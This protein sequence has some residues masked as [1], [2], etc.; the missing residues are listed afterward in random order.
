MLNRLALRLATVRAL[1]GR[2]LAGPNVLDSSSA[3]IDDIAAEHPTP[4]IVVYTDDGQWN[5]AGRDLYATSG[6]TRV[7]MGYQKLLIEI[8][9][10]QRMLL[11]DPAT[12]E[13]QLDADGNP[14]F[15]AMSLATDPALELTLDLIERQVIDALMCGADDAAWPE[16]WRRLVTGVGDKHS[17][18]GASARDGVRFAGRQIAI[19]CALP[20]EPPPAVPIGPLWTDFLALAETEPDL[21]PVLPAIRAQL[22]GRPLDA[23][24]LLIQTLGLNRLE[25]DALLGGEIVVP[26]SVP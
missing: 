4:V 17:V 19:S 14:L 13:P 11:V 25:A 26:E 8:A 23:N 24:G 15:A 7:D 20:K 3:A 1:R 2:T 5:V 9:L 16:M 18:R 22:E 21:A 6:D 10:T 12:G